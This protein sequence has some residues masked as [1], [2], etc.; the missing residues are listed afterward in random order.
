MSPWTSRAAGRDRSA[1]GA[2]A[3]GSGATSRPTAVAS[4]SSSTSAA[5]VAPTIR[6][7]IAAGSS[8]SAG[9]SATTFPRRRM[10]I[11]S[12]RS[13]TS[14]SLCEMNTTAMPCAVSRRIEANSTSTS[15]GTSTAVGSSSTSTRQSP[16][17]ALRISTRCRSPTDSRSTTASG[18]T[19]TPSRSE[20]ASTR[21]RAA[22]RSTR[23]S[24]EPAS[25]RFSVTVIGPT[26]VNSW[27]TMPTPAAS[28]SAGELTVTGC[29]AMRISP[30]SARLSP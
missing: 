25:I 10:L 29:P 15:A 13:T 30:A 2:G 4:A 6:A 16:S 19:G 22:L 8:P 26:S 7:A 9:R 18:S 5:A 23:P 27:V 28:A 1:T 24:G 12:A 3:T 20:A 14:C 17:S 21:A 11:R